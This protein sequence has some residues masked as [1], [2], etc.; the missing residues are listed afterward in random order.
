MPTASY[1]PA[2]LNSSA[3]RLISAAGSFLAAAPFKARR[4]TA[5]LT[6][7][8]ATARLTARRPTARLTARRTTARLT[9]RRAAA[10]RTTRRAAARFIPR[11]TAAFLTTRR[12]R[13]RRTLLARAARLT[14]RAAELTWLTINSPPT[15]RVQASFLDPFAA[16]AR[17]AGVFCTFDIVVA[18]APTTE[19]GSHATAYRIRAP[20]EASN[21][22]H[23]SR[24]ARTHDDQYTLAVPPNGATPQQ[25]ARITER[26]TGYRRLASTRNTKTEND[27]WTVVLEEFDQQSVDVIWSP[28]RPP[29]RCKATDGRG[30]MVLP[31]SPYL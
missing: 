3:I 21:P 28:F 6:A 1:R 30:R 7:R 23:H 4:P 9:A 18:I 11:R 25:C 14:L 8:R 20:A 13:R 15:C 22:Q 2:S 29:T 27:Q 26:L 24:V 5:R 31:M 19:C 16:R 10:R 12:P 17:F